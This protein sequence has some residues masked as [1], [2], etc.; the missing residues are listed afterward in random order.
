MKKYGILCVLLLCVL[1]CKDT[2]KPVKV[3]E[4]TIEEEKIEDGYLITGDA[5]NVDGK[6][7]F[8]YMI[9]PNDSLKLVSST[10]IKNS[11]FK[12]TGKV[13]RPNFY[14]IKINKAQE[15]KILLSNSEH[16]VQIANKNF[17]HKISSTSHLSNSY[18][19][20]HHKLN[21]FRQGEALY[22]D[23]YKD[24]VTQNDPAKI[25][26]LNEKLAEFEGFKRKQITSFITHNREKPLVA[27]ILKDQIDFLDFKVVTSIYDSLP[28]D[29]QTNETGKFIA[30]FIKQKQTKTPVI[31]ETPKKEKKIAPKKKVEFRP[32]AYALSG[33]TP[34]GTTLSLATVSTG[35]VVLIDFWAS[36]C[37]PCRVQSPHIVSLYKKYKDRGLVILSVSEDRDET[38][39]VNAIE[40][41]H[42]TWN[43]H[44]IDNNKSIAFR[45]GIEAIPHTVLIDKN[46]K[47][48]AEKLSGNSLETKI[49]QLLNE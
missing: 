19:L 14:L 3:I 5:L 29:I 47:I 28:S 45:Y 13:A 40:A 7:V 22:R 4:T 48:A 43:T 1:S 37:Q 38:A 16:K 31:V 26:K 33:K 17:E 21:K 30:D 6:E 36:W 34:D 44:I 49:K 27:L 35:K 32:A 39:W 10:I 9:Q 2:S 41:D 42:F 18:A 11:K 24:A 25:A 46:G 12:F 23:I 15:C 8:L 20:L